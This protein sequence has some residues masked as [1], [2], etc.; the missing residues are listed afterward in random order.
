[1]V[2]LK[3]AYRNFLKKGQGNIIKILSLSVGITISMLLV[4]KIFFE[5]SY[6][7]FYPDSD[8]IYLIQTNYK[9]KDQEP[10]KF[11]QTSGGVAQ[12]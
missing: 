5:F 2:N 6:D 10:E 3:L 11:G 4:T 9:L 8:N 12:K 1:M 7:D